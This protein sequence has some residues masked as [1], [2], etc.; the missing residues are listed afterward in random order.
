MIVRIANDKYVLDATLPSDEKLELVTT[1]LQRQLEFHNRT[2]SIEEYFQFTWNNKDTKKAI[3]LIAYY[4]TKEDKDLTT[5]SRKKM[6][7]ISRGS[8]RHI[9]FSAMSITQLIELGLDDEIF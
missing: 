8:D 2:M 9:V 6:K 1:L 3:D 7:E 4:L 5:L